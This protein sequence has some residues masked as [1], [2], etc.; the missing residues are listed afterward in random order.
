MITHLLARTFDRQQINVIV[1][2]ERSSVEKTNGAPV[3]PPLL[4][5]LSFDLLRQRSGGAALA[6]RQF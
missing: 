4:S 2:N 1:S 3:A 6:R 5:L